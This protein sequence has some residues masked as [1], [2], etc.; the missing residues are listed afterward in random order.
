MV[1]GG[2]GREGWTDRKRDREEKCITEAEQE[3]M[4]NREGEKKEKRRKI[5]LVNERESRE[6]KIDRKEEKEEKQTT[7]RLEKKSCGTFKNMEEK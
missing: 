4:M 6:G 2:G 1:N 3:E 5:E 7:S